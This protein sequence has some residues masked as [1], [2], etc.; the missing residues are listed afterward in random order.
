MKLR[1]LLLAIGLLLSNQA[2]ADY[3]PPVMPPLSIP[4]NTSSLNTAFVT[5]NNSCTLSGCSFVGQVLTC[6]G[7]GAGVTSITGDGTIITNNLS[8][9]AVTL[10]TSLTNGDIWIGNVSNAPSAHA[11]SGDC[12]LA[13]NGALTC[14]KTN[15]SSFG[16]MATQN[17]SGVSITGG[18]IDG[19]NIGQTTSANAIIATLTVGTCNGCGGGG[20]GSLAIVNSTSNVTDY[21]PLT[22]ST[23]LSGVT[24][25]YGNSLLTFN[26]STGA[27]GI[28]G[29]LT[30][31][32]TS[33]SAFAVGQNGATNPAL[34]V[35]TNTISSTTGISIISAATG[36]GAALGVTS[37]GTNEAL[38]INSKGSGT[39]NIGG[40]TNGQI[41]LSTGNSSVVIQN[42]GLSRITFNDN[43]GISTSGTSASTAAAAAV[44]YSFAAGADT[45]ITAGANAIITSIGGGVTRQH[46]TG[47]LS[48]Q[49]DTS[50][51]G[52]VDS[53]VGASTLTNGA[54][55]N[56][57]V[58]G[59]GT[60]ATCTNE[61][62]LYIPSQALTATGT[63]TN[64]YGIN[65]AAGTGATN[66]Y[67]VQEI[68]GTLYDYVISKGTKFTTSGCSV[69]STTGGASAGTLTLGANNCS[70]V[71][72][73]NGATGATAPNGW[74]CQIDDQ[75]APTIL[76]G[77]T[78]TTTTTAT[79]SVP[80]TAG[81]TDVLQFG[82][83]GY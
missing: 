73:I 25:L 3:P 54:T 41:N 42:G 48:L 34:T 70:L 56:I 24:T 63:I 75:T 52:T 71:I 17:A 47:A 37:S 53:F 30:V 23:S 58:K 28:P 20:G 5:K 60:N 69:S 67:A 12:T 26:P 39:I 1:L 9:G 22:T 76:I 31:T 29:A 32:A 80:V 18:T 14:T 7:A 11:I 72:T 82:C 21:L 13:N 15:G 44:R 55:L 10:T 64:S 40:N 61:S 83:T 78:S 51:G 6:T 65:V 38:T 79:F 45:A 68:G 4:C 43:G 2:R 46:A 77:Q 16:T 59:C 66:N 27:T 81:A 74:V 50:I 19:T 33:A 35:N 57:G 49:T 8:T 62:A 36:S